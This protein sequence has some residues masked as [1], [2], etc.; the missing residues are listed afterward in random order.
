MK[1]VVVLA[2]LLA[3]LAVKLSAQ[4][5]LSDYTF[6]ATSG[7]FTPIT[8][9]STLSVAG[10][11]ADDGYYPVTAIGFNFQY[12]GLSYTHF[13]AST[14]GAFCI[15]NSSMATAPTS[16]QPYLSSTTPRP[17]FIPL[18]DDLDMIS[19]SF[20]YVVSGAAGNKIF[21]AQWLNVEWR[22]SGPVTIS[23]QVKLYESSGN[24]QFIYRQESGSLTGGE[25]ANIGISGVSTGSGN[26]ISL[27]GSGT[28]PATSMTSEYEYI[29]SKPATGQ[30]YTFA[31]PVRYHADAGVIA[32]DSPIVP[33]RP[34]INN[35]TARIKNF[36]MDTLVSA[37]I[38]WQ[39]NGTGKTGIIWSGSLPKNQVSTQSTLGTHHF[40]TGFNTIKA[41]TSNPN[42]VTDSNKTNDTFIYNFYVCNSM[43]GTYTIG[44]HTTD[45]FPT[46]SAAVNRLI[47]CGISGP[48]LIKADS[49]TYYEQLVIPP[50]SGASATNTITF[51][52]DSGDSTEVVLTYAPISSAD[53]FVVKLDGADFITFR[54]MTLATMATTYSTVIYLTNGACQNKFIRNHIS[55]YYVSSTGSNYTVIYSDGSTL[56]DS[57]NIIDQNYIENGSYGLQFFGPGYPY[58][59]NNNQITNNYFVNQYYSGIMMYYQDNH[60]ISNNLIITYRDYYYFMGMDLENCYGPF[61]TVY[62]KIIAPNLYGGYGIY[63]YDCDASFY[64]PGL[65]ANNFISISSRS[66]YNAY[67]IYLDYCYNQDVFYNSVNVTGNYN[68]TY[69]FYYYNPGYG[70]NNI[71]NNIFANNAGGYSVYYQN[72]YNVVTDYNDLYTSGA[73]LGNWNGTNAG[74]LATWRSISSQ[75]SHSV[76]VNPYYLSNTDLHTYSFDLNG[77]AQVQFAV[78]DDIDHQARSASAPDIGADEYNLLNR[79]IGMFSI[80]SPVTPAPPGVN[81]FTVRFRNFGSDTITSAGLDWKL[82]GITKT[83]K[84]WSGSLPAGAV[85]STISIDTAS[86]AVGTHTLKVWTKNPNASTDQNPVNDTME[87]TFESCV[88]MRGIYTIGSAT[89]DSFPSFTAAINALIYNCGV[90]GPVVFK[91]RNGT[92]YE[93]ITIPYIMGITDTSTITFESMSGDSSAVIL[94]YAPSSYYYNYTVN[95]DG[96]QYVIFK[97]ITITTTGTSYSR[98][99]NIQNGTGNCKFYNNQ[100]IGYNTTSSSDYRAIIYNP[101]NYGYTED[102]NLF[103]NNLFKYGSSG[104]YWYTNSPVSSDNKWLNNQFI[105]QYY[106]GVHIEYQTKLAFENNYMTPSTS[107]CSYYAVNFYNF[108]DEYRVV[109]NKIIAPGICGGTAIYLSGCY[110]SPGKYGLVANNF[111]QYNTSSTNSYG[112]YCNYTSYHQIVYNS[113]NITGSSSYTSS[114]FYYYD[115]ST[116]SMNMALNNIFINNAGTPA[117]LFNGA[118]IDSS[119]YNNLYSTGSI[120]GSYLGSNAYNLAGWQ[121]LSSM[122]MHSKSVPVTFFSSSDLHTTDMSMNASAIPVPSVTTDIDNQARNTTTPDIGADEFSPPAYDAGIFSIDHPGMTFSS[123][124][125]E[126]K[127]RIK[128]Y[129]TDSLFSAD[130][131]WKVNDSTQAGFHW[132]DTLAPNQASPIFTI[133]TFIFGN[134]TYNLK[135]WTEH[136]NGYSDG[137]HIN[138]TMYKTVK[139]TYLCDTFTIGGTGADFPGFTAAVDSMK[140]YGICGP[141]VF[142]VASST[143]TEQISI[144]AISGASS[145]NTITFESASGD[146]ST[147]ILTYSPSSYTQNYIV[148]FTGTRYITFRKM[149]IKNTNTSYGIVLAYSGQSNYNQILNC[150]IET[151]N[152]TSYY[153]DNALV[154]SGGDND[155]FNVFRNSLFKYGSY[156]FYWYG[157]SL[158]A[159]TE[160]RN[161]IFQG[162]YY[163]GIGTYYQDGIVIEGNILTGSTYNYWYGIY[164]YNCNNAVKVIRNKITSATNGGY[165]IYAG[166][167]YGSSSN[168]ALIANNFISLYSTG[169]SCVGIYVDYSQFVNY[170]YNS[171]NLT[172]NYNSSYALYY[173]SYYSSNDFK[174]NIFS[175]QANGYAFYTSYGTGFTSDYNDL[176]TTGLNLG[177]YSGDRS[178]LSA[179]KLATAKD[180]HS[181][182]KNPAF[183][184]VSD[185]HTVLKDLNGSAVPVSSVTN[186]IDG[187]IRD[188][189]HPDIGADEFTPPE[190]DAGIIALDNPT[191]PCKFGSQQIKVSI[192]NFGTDTLTSATVQWK[193]DGVLQSSFAWADTLLPDD[194]AKIVTIDTVSLTYGN[195]LLKLW[196]NFPNSTTDGNK[197]ND[198][199]QVTISARNPLNGT[200][201]IGPH[202]TDSFR[203]F[204]EAVDSLISS[205]ISGKVTFLVKDSTYDE[206]LIIPQIIGASDTKN[207]TFQSATG[208]STKVI[209]QYPAGYNE[210]VIWLNGA[211][212]FTF[213]GMTIKNT[214]STYSKIIGINNNANYNTFM[215][216]IIQGNTYAT[217]YSYNSLLYSDNTTD[218]YLKIINNIFNNGSFGVYLSGNNSS[219]LENGLTI[220]DNKF[221]NQYYMGIYLYY[222]INNPEITGNEITTNTPYTLFRGMYLY[223][224]YNKVLISKNKINIPNGGYGIYAYNFNSNSTNNSLIANN[225]IRIGGTSDAIGIY[226][227]YSNY[228]NFYYN[229]INI[230]S[231][232][233]GSSNNCLYIY[234][235]NN[236]NLFNNIFCNTGGGFAIYAGSTGNLNNSDYNDLYTTGANLCYYSGNRTNLAQWQSASYKDA[237]SKSLNPMYLS[238]NDLHIREVFL[239]AAG[240]P[241]P[242][243]TDDIDGDIRN[244]VHPDIGAD[245]FFPAATDAGIF[246]YMKPLVPFRA[247]TQIIAV[248]LRN[249]GLDTLKSVTIN[250]KLRGINRTP[251]NWNGNL[252]TGDTITVNIGRHVFSIDSTYTLVAWTSLPNGMTDANRSND[253]L[254]TTNIHA[255]LIGTYTI[256]G[257]SPDFLNFTSA[258]NALTLGGILGNVT[259]NVRSGIYYEPLDIPQIV[260]STSAGS[261]IFQSQSGDSN[262]VVLQNNGSSTLNFTVRLNGADGIVFRKMTIKG[263]NSTYCRIFDFSNSSTNN[264]IE[265]CVINGVNVSTTSNGN[266]LVYF[267]NNPSHNNSFINNRFRYGS[268]AFYL[269]NSSAPYLLNTKIEK[270]TFDSQYYQGIYAYY[271]EGLK[272]NYNKFNYLS[273]TGY[274]CYTIY[275]SNC[276]GRTIVTGNNIKNNR[277]GYVIYGY[278]VQA[279]SSE[280]SLFSNNYISAG[281]SYESY[282]FYLYYCNYLN[283]YNNS[284]NLYTTNTYS[285]AIYSNSG[286]D[287]KLVNNI[288]SAPGGG[289][290]LYISSPSAITRS[291]Y[292][293]LYGGGSNFAYW[294]SSYSNL[295]SLQ[296]ASSKDSHSISKNPL[297]KSNTDVH[298]REIALNTNAIP[299]PE[300]PLDIDGETRDIIHPDIGADEFTPQ[301]HNEAGIT[302]LVNPVCPFPKDTNNVTV[303]ISNYGAD[304]LKSLT[305]NWKVN[306][307]AKA[308]YPWTGRLLTGTRDTVTIGKYDF[309]TGLPYNLKVYSSYPNGVPDSFN[310]ND[311]IFVNNLYA[312]LNGVYTIGGTNPDFS[313]FNHAA[314][315][316]NLGGVL[317]PV[318]LNI[319]SGIYNEEVS[320]NQFPGTSSARPVTFQSELLDSTQVV[321]TYPHSWDYNVLLLNGTDYVTFR[322]MTFRSTST[323]SSERLVE[324]RNG[325]TYNSFTNNIFQAY[326]L[327]SGYDLYASVYSSGDNDHHNS[328]NNNFIIRGQYGLLLEGVGSSST[329]SSNLIKGNKF[330]NQYYSAIYGYYLD[331]LEIDHNVITSNSTYGFFRGIY[332]N[333]SHYGFKINFNK[334]NVSNGESGIYLYACAGSS[335]SRSVASNNFI[336]SG[337]TSSSMGIYA[338]NSSYFDFYYNNILTTGSHTTNGRSIY[339]YSS[340]YHNIFN[341]NFINT[342]GGYS[343]YFS[344]ISGFLSDNN[345]FYT[346]G[347]NLGYISSNITSLA[348]WKT[349]SS[350][351]THSVSVNPYYISNTDLHV[352]QITLNGAARPISGITKDIDEETRNSAHPDIGADEFNVPFANDAGVY[353]IDVPAQVFPADTLPVKVTLK[354][355]GYDTLKSVSIRWWVN[356]VS[357]PS[358]SWT[359]QIAPGKT[360]TFT[361]GSYI[362]RIATGYTLIASTYSPNG[363]T[364]S[365]KV[366]DTSKKYNVYAG[367]SGTYTIGGSSPDFINFLSA[368]NS[369]NYGGVYGQVNFR[370]R[371]GVYN[372]QIVLNQISG[373]SATN[374]I[375]FESEGGDSNLVRLTYTTTSSQ[376]YVLLL[377]GTDYVTFHKMTFQ[378]I[379]ISYSRAVEI[380]NMAS[381][382]KFLNNVFEGYTGSSTS[383]NAAIIYS[384][385]SNDN[386][387]EFRNNLFNNGSY[388]VYL[389]G[390]SSPYET[391]IVISNNIFSNQYYTGIFLYYLSAPVISFN[392]LTPRNAYSSQI[393]ISMQSCYDGTQIYSNKIILNTD[394]T[395]IN[396]YDVDGTSGTHMRVYNNFIYGGGTNPTYGIYISSSSNND[397]IFNNIH[398]AAS[399]I[400][401]SKCLYSDY[402]NSNHT[403]KNNILSNSGGGYSIYVYSASSVSDCDYNN[404]YTTGANLGYWSG[405]RANLAAW[406]SASGFDNHSKSLDPFFFSATDLH[407]SQINMDSSAVP[408]Y[409][410][411]QDIDMQ[412]RNSI[413]PDIGADEFSYVPHDVGISAVIRPGTGCSLSSSDSVIVRIQ[414]FGGLTQSGFNVGFQLD[415]NPPVVKNIGSSSIA[416]G[417]SLVFKFDTFVN[418]TAFK[419]YTLKC[420]TSLS[421]DTV[422][423]NDTTVLTFGNYQSPNAVTNMLP[424]DSTTNLSNYVTFSWSPS[425]GA[426]AYDLYIWFDSLSQPVSPTVANITQISYTMNTSLMYGKL[427]KWRIVAKN[428]Y[429]QTAGPIQRFALRYL[430]DLIVQSVTVPASA[431]SGQSFTVSWQIKNNGQGSTQSTS[432]YDIAYLST[433]AVLNTSNDYYLGGLTNMSS[434][435]PNQ[436]YNQSTNFIIPQGYSGNF[437][438]FIITDNYNYLLETNEDNNTGNNTLPMLVILTPPP[439]L[440]VTNII[441]PNTAYSGTT[442]NITW[443]VKNDG[444]GNTTHNDWYDAI[445]LG[446]DTSFN[447]SNCYYLGNYHHLGLLMADSTYSMTR[448]INLPNAIYGNYYIY[449]NTDYTNTEYEHALENNNVLRSAVMT[450]VLTPPPDLVIVGTDIPDTVNSNDN[451][452]F[453]F[454]LQNQGGNS[455][456]HYWYDQIYL[457]SSKTF[458]A[459]SAINIGSRYH[460]AALDPGNIDTLFKTVHIPDY[461]TGKYYVF[462]K[463]DVNNDVFEYIYE[464]NNLSS[465]DSVII[466]SPDLVANSISNDDTAWSGTS[467]SFAWKDKNNGPGKLITQ[468]WKD[469]IYISTFATYNPA[470]VVLLKEFNVSITTLNPGASKSNSTTINIPNGYSGTYYLYVQTDY[471]NNINE[472][473]QEGNNITKSDTA[474]YVRL[475]PWPDLRVTSINVQD[476]ATAG[477]VVNF[478]F[479]VRNTGTAPASGSSWKDVVYLSTSPLLDV[480]SAIS[481]REITHASTLA[482]TDSYNITTMLN[483]GSSLTG[484]RYYLFV[485]TDNE[486]KIYEHTGNN[487]NDSS[488]SIYISPYPPVDF[489]ILNVSN[490]DTAISG[491]PFNISYSVKNIGQGRSLSTNYNNLVY[492]STDSIWSPS[493]D[494]PV[495]KEYISTQLNPGASYNKNIS[496][497]IP[498][499]LSGYYYLLVITDENNAN[500]DVNT[501]NNYHARVDAMNRMIKTYIKLPL[502]PD[503]TILSLSAPPTGTSGQSFNVTWTVKNQ[504]LA[505]SSLSFKD[506]FY[507]S[508]DFTLDWSDVCIGEYIRTGSLGVNATYTI[509]QGF[510]IPGSVTGNRIL[511]VK[512][513]AEDVEYEHNAENN[514]LSSQAMVISSAPPSDLVVSEITIPSTAIAGENVTISWKVKNRG[515][516]PANG[517]VKDA[518]YI[519]RDTIWDVGD[520]LF[521]TREGYISLAPNA[522]ITDNMTIPLTGVGLGYF[523]VIVRT[524]ILNYITES[525]DN[526]NQKVSSDSMRVTVRNLPWHTLT[527]DTL[528]NGNNLYFKLESHDTLKYETLLLTMKGDSIHGDNELYLKYLNIPSRNVYDYASSTPYSGNQEII[529]PSLEDSTYYITVFGNTTAG[530]QQKISLYA[531]IMQFELRSVNAD[532]GGNSGKVTFV[533]EGSKFDPSINVRLKGDSA[534]YTADTLVFVN[535]T[536]VFVTFDLTGAKRGIYDVEAFKSNGDT[537]RLSDGF[538]IVAG[539]PKDLQ[540]NITRPANVRAQAI[541]SMTVEFINNGNTDIDVPTVTL[542]SL[543]GAPVGFTLAN[544]NLNLTNLQLILREINGPSYVLRPGA[545]GSIVVYTK[546][547]SALGFQINLPEIK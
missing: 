406:R 37:G 210:Y 184:S 532:E 521:G 446:Q 475:S 546:S 308:A 464:N 7:T 542:T 263:L 190:A 368:A 428:S 128:N 138:D 36:G 134:G 236:I 90:S 231:T 427:Y 245:E 126:V 64:S 104:V 288:F 351:D 400:T 314:T 228:V 148:A 411:T 410:I 191:N 504:G 487:N 478:N 12:L 163:M 233:S 58:N 530:I 460:P 325:S 375:I 244:S 297:F 529:V 381:N 258:V 30:T 275:M 111:I 149:T 393:G 416:R 304:T 547:S 505:P 537:A 59:E 15:G 195:H 443:T 354:N 292:N 1:K 480:S 246:A 39:V 226:F 140:K 35:V 284:V 301:Y 274:T 17:V 21:T 264:R 106:Y 307:T 208:D 257:S 339:L 75:D 287:I 489:K 315:S 476:S 335:S 269:Y 137:N 479:T 364:D 203:N 373:A 97:K 51:Q 87:V 23:F 330:E 323:S 77:K 13:S 545:G 94:T 146:S 81:N 496:V 531:K 28:S 456:D 506:K 502:T 256:G 333:E 40:P 65:T 54:Q 227:Y 25:S 331:N 89:T 115:W 522:E 33:V 390:G 82:D 358:K 42:S 209:L 60:L 402:S 535:S 412:T 470:S 497:S 243:I 135:I 526:N 212:F 355:Y 367:L 318:T 298:V 282:P 293:N 285:R 240:T 177:Y 167:C 407:V 95:L 259:F 232:Y 144:P 117:V 183:F 461:L 124:P 110:G 200:Y 92:Y 74:S 112:I 372:E 429:C 26:F 362:F 421:T 418:L 403:Y 379:G 242:G 214:N 252:A 380:R 374:K 348:G 543:V 130:V 48:V 431:Y 173:Y 249:Y 310:T 11:S 158:E 153:T 544:L 45:S 34:G 142:R 463:A 218:H 449:V 491:R 262:S 309:N 338:Y 512:T 473:S 439:D 6:T 113:V 69:G 484:G 396:L 118:A 327:A 283:I 55:G 8:G 340:S 289:Y 305:I 432:W 486:D 515:A 311:T 299:L 131:K 116:G 525:N 250:W 361:I 539:I 296:A 170:Y 385:S 32:I 266:A 68:M 155:N 391:G 389:I 247:D 345:N 207:I 145:T 136:P 414:N 221:N 162:N 462:I 132:A 490:P 392:Q 494:I 451:S 467:I 394:G 465:P 508:T 523:H 267:Y 466:I 201:T 139:A 455:P 2:M 458:N 477:E 536:K 141:I 101:G 47:N 217:T 433:D 369:L 123:G 181:I 49:G 16:T 438:V 452:L 189:S 185:L 166:N 5:N 336:Y 483:L 216:N 168:P 509:T 341:N 445:Y 482:A 182:S 102:S 276:Y 152:Q 44:P 415:N 501:G 18:G 425:S 260:G 169:Y 447:P 53:N 426:T 472:G 518:V 157:N 347:P 405:N 174:N 235:G 4:T 147:V 22:Y 254:T 164:L 326:N 205:G 359:G 365:L 186:D 222:Y 382:N 500:N 19:G 510:I 520:V 230:T 343:A 320:L 220:R 377:D 277:N 96:A 492:L 160:I 503:L 332:L 468:S 24:I 3:L 401:T 193:L 538:T 175:N 324:I 370:V 281:G 286:S 224:P 436:T 80:I 383:E 453:E 371:T 108:S 481:L 122:D 27:Q 328:F 485:Y 386:G 176:F 434:L 238:P 423:V 215:N 159:G 76:S 524:D 125:A 471:Y 334:I 316:L 133:D 527:Y 171:V 187:E 349:A 408:F 493:S 294:G 143:Y 273:Y 192:K 98:L 151:A 120:L 20:S 270:N 156:A 150:V 350:L 442:T 178:D 397:I 56:T 119:D 63:M 180:F 344:G 290:A 73:V 121:T 129:G 100:L 255:A 10:G 430:P 271:N 300:V 404:L 99:I 86:I 517:S 424:A 234:S 79:D 448:S 223:Y 435:G 280:P 363:Y 70:N 444:S 387:N 241:I 541:T 417:S 88:P 29:S 105:S 495:N 46:F 422:H 85:T 188:T 499:G 413:K 84:P 91:V 265:N 93:Q 378:P 488:K 337:G 66:S 346:S 329:E 52:S 302:A 67:G 474:I 321:L 196:T 103:C 61:R 384:S 534:T 279:S 459:S 272:I 317:G 528:K 50:I 540:V 206:K 251:F 399:G 278:A 395:G 107:S 225:F 172:G 127:V 322:K 261:I 519:S 253:T 198:T 450:I 388:G 41:W 291:D 179:W 72:S 62:N 71:K 437:Y 454:M 229:N 420:Y 204:T 513:D 109:A 507:F 197:Y 295:A 268:I 312:A 357:Q 441:R 514:N 199:L 78:P 457:S 306:D 211:D 194:T 342:G 38:N 469:R 409:G 14:N 516:N 498:N 83:T 237:H 356:G 202:F 360:D 313:G 43:S 165:G 352:R 239:N 154:Y 248:K 440:V 353:N 31:P 9:G 303:I 319:R 511:L 398:I 213:R 219:E 114:P 419:T 376:N 161:N 57:S 533:M 366:N